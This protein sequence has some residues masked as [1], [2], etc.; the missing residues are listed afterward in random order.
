MAG[1]IQ[2]EDY[3]EELEGAVLEGGGDKFSIMTVIY[4]RRMVSV[5]S[6]LSFLSVGY[7][8]KAYHYSLPLSLL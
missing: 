5:L 7:S 6:L 8:S 2:L 4:P 3:E 1:R